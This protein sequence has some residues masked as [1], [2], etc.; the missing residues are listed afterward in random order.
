[1]WDPPVW[2]PRH[3]K[4]FLFFAGLRSALALVGVLE[5]EQAVPANNENGAKLN[6]WISCIFLSDE[7]IVLSEANST[8][9]GTKPS[10]ITGRM[11]NLTFRQLILS[12][13]Y[14]TLYFNLGEN[15]IH[16]N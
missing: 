14:N 5:V 6:K 11:S 7:F 15:L 1:M 16:L 3:Q 13:M 9:S 2:T 4:Q 12:T 10:G 8:Y